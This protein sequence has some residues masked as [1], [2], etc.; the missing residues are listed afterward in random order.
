MTLAK[1][2]LKWCEDTIISLSRTIVDLQNRIEALEDN[3]YITPQEELETDKR[4]KQ[5]MDYADVVLNY[6]PYAKS[7]VGDEE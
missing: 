5:F 3:S 4:E 1:K 6:N 2:K 7:K